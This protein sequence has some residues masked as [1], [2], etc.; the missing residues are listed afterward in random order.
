MHPAPEP[1]ASLVARALAEDV[2]SGDVTTLAT[3]P[4]AQ[5]GLGVFLVKSAC[6]LAGSAVA[7]EVFQ[8]LEPDA[9]VVWHRRDGQSLEPG[10]VVAEVQASART[11]LIGER[12]ALNLLQRLSGIATLTRAYVTAAAGRI[13]VLDTRKT[14]PGLRMLEK[15]AVLAGGAVNHRVGLHDAVLIKD[16]HVRLAGGVAAAVQ[17]CRAAQPSMFV[18]VEVQTL[19]EVDEA[20]RVAP[21]RILLD[22]MTT[23]MITTAVARVA[24]RIPLE[25]SG[26]VTLARM[27]ELAATGAQYVSVGALTHSAPAADISFEITP[28]P[29]A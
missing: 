3:V 22:N 29:A 28:V 11:L 1:L 9:R 17:A 20:L 19:D 12:T 21:D 7:T 18:E 10:T 8:Q 2:G 6:V 15:Q 26:G 23:P 4:A 16:N 25:L 13:T 27:P 14:T 5:R 24:G